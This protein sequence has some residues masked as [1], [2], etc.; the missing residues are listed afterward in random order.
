MIFSKHMRNILEGQI[1]FVEKTLKNKCGLVLLTGQNDSPLTEAFED[2][3]IFLSQKKR[4]VSALHNNST[5]SIE[6]KLIKWPDNVKSTFVNPKVGMSYSEEINKFEP[7]ENSVLM[8]DQ[9]IDTESAKSAF[10]F[11][12]NKSLVISSIRS[13]ECASG[14][15]RLLDMGVSSAKIDQ[16]LLA[17]IALA[18]PESNAKKCTILA[19]V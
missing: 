3:S 13:T 8:I 5:W 12:S 15:M 11:A 1:S 17:I 16:T 18:T 2:F 4:K 14:I 7:H 6:D 19:Y 10:E 9:I